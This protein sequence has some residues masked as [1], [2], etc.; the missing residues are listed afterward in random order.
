M[1]ASHLAEKAKKEE[2]LL[3]SE[4]SIFGVEGDETLNSGCERDLEGFIRICFA[5]E[6]EHL[7]EEGVKRLARLIGSEQN[8]LK[9]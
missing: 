6:E 2:N 1:K 4:G 5:W 9:R 8:A 7:L 3:I